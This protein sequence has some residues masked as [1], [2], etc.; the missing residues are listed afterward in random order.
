LGKG[1]GT[2]QPAVNPHRGAA[3][4]DLAVGDFDKDGN[5][6][7]AVTDNGAWAPPLVAP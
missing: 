1:D 2:F 7:L 3:P 5:P 6:D 4:N